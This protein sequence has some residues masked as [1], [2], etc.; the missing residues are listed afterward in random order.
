MEE[1]RLYEMYLN[2]AIILKASNA[3]ILP[4]KYSLKFC[5]KILDGENEGTNND[6]IQ[7]QL[8]RSL[9]SENEEI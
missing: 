8:L 4:S 5:A 3:F 7:K 2:E 6:P 1:K 9:K